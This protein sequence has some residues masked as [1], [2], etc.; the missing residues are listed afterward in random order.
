MGEITIKNVTTRKQEKD[1][2]MLPWKIYKGDEC[3]VPQLI[4]DYKKAITIRKRLIEQGFLYYLSYLN[5]GE[6][7]YHQQYI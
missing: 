2:I 1:F 3:W 6:K 4:S 7:E 5:L